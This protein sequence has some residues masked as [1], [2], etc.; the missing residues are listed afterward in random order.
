[1]AWF[2]SEGAVSL[3]RQVGA[4]SSAVVEIPVPVT[5][6]ADGDGTIPYTLEGKLFAREDRM[7][8]SWD[9]AVR[10]ALG[11]AAGGAAGPVRVTVAG[12]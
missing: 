7:E 2:E 9:V 11:A 8:R 12:P 6:P 10:G 4:G 1:S 5:H 3:S